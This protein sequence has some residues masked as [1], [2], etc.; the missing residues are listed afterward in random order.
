MS[1][2]MCLPSCV[3][4]KHFSWSSTKVLLHTVLG[5]PERLNP[6]QA[7]IQWWD[8]PQK[9]VTI[10]HMATQEPSCTSTP[11]VTSEFMV[12]LNVESDEHGEKSSVEGAK[13]KQILRNLKILNSY[14]LELDPTHNH[15]DPSEPQQ[16]NNTV[17]CPGI[18]M[19]CT[20]ISPKLDSSIILFIL[21]RVHYFTNC[22]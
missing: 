15:P 19:Y 16:I 14:C 7:L 18:C 10:P 20:G 12:S 4:V 5:S 22:K 9:N 2:R 1:V 11:A 8:N 21:L 6:V 3:A 13:Q 17:S